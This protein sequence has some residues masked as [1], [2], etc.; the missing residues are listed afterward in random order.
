MVENLIP[1]NETAMICKSIEE[2][3][4]VTSQVLNKFLCEYCEVNGIKEEDLKKHLE[5]VHNPLKG[6]LI[7][8][9]GD[10]EVFRE[11]FSGLKQEETKYS[12][13]YDIYISNKST[14]P[15][16]LSFIKEFREKF[17][18]FAIGNK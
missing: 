10:V 17:E 1:Q 4:S 8:K 2:M 6:V 5:V 13:N 9:E 12:L 11:I 7:V 18:G 14:Y 16:T 15:K 3:A